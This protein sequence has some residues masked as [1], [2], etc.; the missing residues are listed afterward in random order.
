MIATSPAV[1]AHRD[2]DTVAPLVVVEELV[3]EP[4]RLLDGLESADATARIRTLIATI[5]IAGGVFGGVVGAH[6]GG[7]QVFY[8]ALKIPLLLLV[9]LVI[10][11]PAFVGLSRAFGVAAPAREVVIVT[12]A[13]C[14]RVAL[15]LAGLAPVV[16]LLAGWAGYHGTVLL[17]AM[18]TGA[19]G[20]A[21]ATL[22]VRAFQRRGQLGWV[23]GLAMLAV[24]GVVG[25]QTGWL[26]RPFVVRPRATHV[27]FA[28]WPLEGDPFGAV[29]ASTRSV[30]GSY[31][32]ESGAWLGAHKDAK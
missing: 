28:H 30:S 29:R 10:C 27:V 1:S 5:A 20:L 22:L 11:V 23:A 14:A 15:V 13:A 6:H 4:T 19:A 21:G 2:E 18:A 25:A 26:L 24:Y 7:V 9:T 8:A 16:W 12:L 31:D 32:D 3:R 17:L